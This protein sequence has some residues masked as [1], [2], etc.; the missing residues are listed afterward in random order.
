MLV[1]RPVKCADCSALVYRCG[2]R[3]LV[4]LVLVLLSLGVLHPLR[5]LL[6]RR[7]LLLELVILHKVEGARHACCHGDTHDREFGLWLCGLGQFFSMDGFLNRERGRR[8]AGFV[9]VVFLED[10]GDVRVYKRQITT[11][12]YASRKKVQTDI[13]LYRLEKVQH[14]AQC[15]RSV[16]AELPTLQ[17]WPNHQ[18]HRVQ[19]GHGRGGRVG[20]RA[21]WWLKWHPLRL[22]QYVV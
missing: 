1:R 5:T 8:C 10:C 7:L 15:F 9:M 21:S 16:Q 4:V 2:R 22:S 18:R 11:V 13:G 20:W 3:G 12:I 14:M 17:Q 19:G 6:E